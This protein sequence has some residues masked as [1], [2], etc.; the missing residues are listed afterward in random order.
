[1]KQQRYELADEAATV[2]LGARLARAMADGGVVYLIGE[3]GAGKTTLVRGLLQALGH[4]GPVKSPTYTLVE[5]YELGGRRIYH[6]DLYRLGD[7][8][9]LEY[10]GGRD[11]FAD[12]E[13]I[14]LLEWPSRG[15]GMIP[16]ADLIVTL[17]YQG[18][19]REAR[20]DFHGAR[21]ARLADAVFAEASREAD[22]VA[23]IQRG[24]GLLFHQWRD[25][26]GDGDTRL[27]W[28]VGF[29]REVDQLRAR[30]PSAM[31][32]VLTQQHQLANGSGY[33][34]PAQGNL[35][36]EPE[37]ALQVSADVA[38]DA[39]ADQVAAAIGRYAAALELVD[40]TRT[41]SGH[42]GDMLAGNLFHEAVLI[43]EPSLPAEAYSRPDLQMQLLVNDTPVATLAQDRVPEDFV[44][45]VQTV[46]A[47][48]ASQGE[49]LKAGD[50][51]ITGAAAA[52][53]GVKPG[54]TIRLTMES[55]GELTLR[56]E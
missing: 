20:F 38:A 51:I 23:D 45:L 18:A 22:V 13:A 37:V 4:D 8:E 41:Q 43:A 33:I 16:G 42:I 39:S 27:G 48:L 55:L 35:L 40:T 24:M 52:P 54:D 3:L 53:V 2:R 17:R 49:Q 31:I 15:E 10:I 29:N 21:G 56:L 28:K 6:F 44:G 25:A 32:G 7:P 36:V 14:C 34:V 1:M 50:W 47:L 19:G 5:P 11:Y 9:E 26:L 12:P 46:A 30:L